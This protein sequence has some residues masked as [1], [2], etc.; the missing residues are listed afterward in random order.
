MK[1]TSLQVK[2]F[3][4]FDDVSFTFTDN[5]A[6]VAENYQ[7]KT[8]IAEANV[9]GLYGCTLTGSPRTDHFTRKGQKRADVVVAFMVDGEEHE[10]HR[11]QA[12]TAELY[13]DGKKATQSDID[14]IVGTKEKFLAVY[15]P[16]YFT[17]Q[18]EKDGREMVMSLIKLPKQEEVIAKL[19]AAYQPLL[20]FD[21]LSPDSAA[22][23]IR[24]DIKANEAELNRLEGK[25]EVLQDRASQV[26][27]QER[28]FDTTE[29]EAYRKTLQS[30]QSDVPNQIRQLQSE[31]TNLRKQY[32]ML[33][34]Q[35]KP[36]PQAPYHDGDACPVCAQTMSG[37]ALAHA[38]QHHTMQTLE[39][40]AKNE[41]LKATCKSLL[42]KGKAQKAELDQLTESFDGSMVVNVQSKIRAL[43][44]EQREIEIHNANVQSVLRE[45]KTASEQLEDVKQQM[46]SCND[47]IFQGNETL[48]AIGAYRAK[49]AEMQVE[50]LKQ[51]LN[52]V[53]IELFKVTKTTGEIKDCFIV[54][55]DGREYKSLSYSEQIRASLE[56]STLF[57]KAMGTS[58][59]VFIDNAESITHFDMPA[60]E[61]LFTAR[62][63]EGAV[64]TVNGKPDA[65]GNV[66]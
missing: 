13:L 6:I 40:A 2:N 15:W 58:Y 26:V 53:D 55:Y 52:R 29:L 59:P 60:T 27:P 19:D 47:A 61:Q 33:K 5:T 34:V 51:H 65:E 35:I 57:N 56:I 43:E 42:D 36:I 54:T 11:V 16:G 23:D 3:K 22:K 18:P 66:A 9:Y 39:I 4:S 8:T 49:V 48:K 44:S 24:A 62:V 64:L 32:D 12:K 1:I 41:Q 45:I 14:R 38:L 7:G 50:Q 25:L 10:V 21:L 20:N 46:Q 28:T 30:L 37:D 63:A 31:Q 17:S